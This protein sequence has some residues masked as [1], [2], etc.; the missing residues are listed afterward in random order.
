MDHCLNSK[1]DLRWVTETQAKN[2]P[3]LVGLGQQIG[4]KYR[5]KSAKFL[6][7]ATPDVDNSQEHDIYK[8]GND[9]E[10]EL[11]I[12]LVELVDLDKSL[13]GIGISPIKKRNAKRT[14]SYVPRKKQRQQEAISQKIDPALSPGINPHKKTYEMMNIQARCR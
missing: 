12:E 4:C 2:Y 5:K 7:E 1:K 8:L 3:K 11:Q 10:P 13:E 9:D 6:I 14:L